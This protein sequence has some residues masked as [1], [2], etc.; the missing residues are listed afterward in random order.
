[1]RG[2]VAA[3]GS[4]MIYNLQILLVFANFALTK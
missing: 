4:S 2:G 3:D 1:M